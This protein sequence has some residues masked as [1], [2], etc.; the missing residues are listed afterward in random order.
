MSQI[1]AFL[2]LL[3]SLYA[4]PLLA[5]DERKWER[6]DYKAIERLTAERDSPHSYDSLF[7]RYR[8]AD[9]TLTPGEY[10]LLYYGYFFREEFEEGDGG[11][12]YDSIRALYQ[13][14][15]LSQDEW[16]RVLGLA[17]LAAD[18]SP[19]SPRVLLTLATAYKM[20]GDSV[21]FKRTKKKWDGVF[22]T[23]TSSGDGLTDTSAF[24]VTAVGHEY[25]V[26]RAFGFASRG[27]SLTPKLCDYLELRP[28]D[29]DVKGLY[30]D[31]SQL[32]KVRQR[33]WFGGSFQSDRKKKRR[34]KGR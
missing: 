8:Q 13:K 23:I 6:P 30:F 2:V 34:G 7:A 4:V 27:Q 16:R 20:T 28:N 5:Q 10:R 29:Y 14:D 21:L 1:S 9:S 12:A 25:D 17:K 33:T 32:F 22:E 15:T 26:L 31:V 24:H 18:T 19:Y 3:Y 11:A